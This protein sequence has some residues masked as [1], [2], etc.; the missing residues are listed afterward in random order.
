MSGLSRE[1]RLV[2]T[3]VTLADTLVVGYDV[4]DLLQTLVDS[5]A[6]LL[7]AS[8]AGIM[9]ADDDGVLSVVASTSES[10]RLVDLM[11]LRSGLGPCVDSYTSGATISVADVTATDGRWPGFTDAA[12]EQ[13]F[14]AVHAVPLRLR[15]NVIGTLNLF[16]GITGALN[17]EDASVAQG[18][19]DV[20]TIGIL[21]ERTIREE[22]V[23][24]EQ[25]QNALT[26]RVV[27]EQAKGVVA[28]LHLVDMDSAFRALRDYARNN[29]LSL[30]DV[31]ELVVSRRLTI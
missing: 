24:R 3:F 28:Q 10:S 25:L 6:E 2:S 26:S 20:A 12:L 15:S 17:E 8:A 27:I 5:S 30:R 19:A 29:R 4:V 21:Q 23:A 14:H 7:D 16:R 11:Q 13:G 22:S 9:L 31:A 18:L 1:A